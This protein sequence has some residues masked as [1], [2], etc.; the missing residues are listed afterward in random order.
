[1]AKIKLET[2]ETPINRL[3]FQIIDYLLFITRFCVT[4][5]NWLNDHLLSGL[6]DSLVDSF[7]AWYNLALTR[8]QLGQI[9]N[10]M[11]TGLRVISYDS[12]PLYSVITLVLDPIL[13]H[14]PRRESYVRGV[15]SYGSHVEPDHIHY[16]ELNSK[17]VKLVIS[18]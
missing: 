13:H 15:M 6:L 12:D 1:M 17:T 5:A 3:H 11:Y 14:D 9:K 7:S 18:H 8:H 4:T 2:S 16:S 10:G